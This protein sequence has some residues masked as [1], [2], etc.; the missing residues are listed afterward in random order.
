MAETVDS[1][2]QTYDASPKSAKMV[3]GGAGATTNSR[4]E[5]DT[6][7]PF[8][9]VEEAVIHFGG[10]G[11]WIPR[12]QEAEEFDMFKLEERAAEMLKDL[13]FKEQETLDILKEL[14][15]TKRLLE[16]LKLKVQ[17]EASECPAALPLD[18][19]MAIP[20]DKTCIDR[21]LSDSTPTNNNM[22]LLECSNLFSSSSAELIMMELKQAKLNLYQS[23]NDLAAIRAS[24][25][26]LNKRMEREKNS[27]EN[28]RE[29]QPFN[30]TPEKIAKQRAKL[31]VTNDASGI[32]R[33]LR[34]LNYEA[35]Q[36]MRTAEAAR[37]EVLKAMSD[38]EQTKS[39]LKLIEMK[40]VA[41]KKL[42]EAA[43]AAEAVALAE[44]RAISNSESTSESFQQ[45]PGRIS[46][47]FDEYSS[48]ANK[49]RKA[50]SLFRR[51]DL[52]KLEETTEKRLGEMALEEV[53]GRVDAVNRRKLAA[54]EALRRL[55][56][57]AGQ[58]KPLVQNGRDSRLL[59][60]NE[61]DYVPNESKPAFR[62]TTSVGDLLSRK[63]VARADLDVERREEGQAERQRVSLNQMLHKHRGEASPLSKRNEKNSGDTNKFSKRK[64]LGFVH[65]SLPLSKQSKNKIQGL[66]FW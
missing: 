8:A 33:E 52:E 24:I 41:A 30:A 35:E 22:K 32:S 29:R 61:F 45:K 31:Q 2:T 62:P 56:S 48:L 63:L 12:P 20:V 28:A 34:E 51:K 37:A 3:D 54:E 13:N 38:I 17:K 18:R 58:R 44:I 42:E 55:G 49:A 1:A 21:D 47:S 43:R 39:G 53:L 16:E 50:D 27:L 11:F 40:W 26:C 46:L 4:V 57:D 19:Q 9:S 15:L 65:I 36:F 7:P 25:E 14:E 6:S 66:N 23:T 59:N 60:T 10:R 5:I 64:T